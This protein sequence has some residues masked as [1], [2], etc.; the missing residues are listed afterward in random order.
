[1]R[2]ALGAVTRRSRCVDRGPVTEKCL[3]LLMADSSLNY[4]D[5]RSRSLPKQLNITMLCA[6]IPSIVWAVYQH[7]YK[8]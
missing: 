8:H 6:T 3:H 1:M 5:P 4:I 2:V 7:I